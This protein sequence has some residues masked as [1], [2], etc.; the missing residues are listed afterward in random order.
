MG[1]YAARPTF[2]WRRLVLVEGPKR[3]DQLADGV[4]AWEE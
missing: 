4:R 2:A 1:K 3:I